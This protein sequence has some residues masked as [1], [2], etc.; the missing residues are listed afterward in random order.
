MSDGDYLRD[1][2]L[3]TSGS[4]FVHPPGDA[5]VSVF[6]VVFLFIPV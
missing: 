5:L 2:W 1:N 3:N 6:K 4:F